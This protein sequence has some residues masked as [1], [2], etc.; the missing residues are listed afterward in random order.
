MLPNKGM[1]SDGRLRRPQLVPRAFGRRRQ[2]RKMGS[3]A[4]AYIFDD[5]AYRERVLP[6]LRRFVQT[7]GAD[8]WLD[9]LLRRLAGSVWEF[10]FPRI[11]GLGF[12]FDDVCDYL[13]TDFSFAASG[14]DQWSYRWEPRA[15][16]SATCPARELC[17]LHRSRQPPAA[18]DFNF[19]L[20]ACVVDQCLGLGQ[21]LGRTV[22]PLWYSDTLVA[23]GFSLEHP[24]FDCLRKL[25]YRGFVVGYQFA[26]SDGIHGW[27]TAGETEAFHAHLRGLD[28]PRFESSFAAMEG[29]R[30]DGG[31]E[32]PPQ[33][34]F[35]QLSLAFLRTVAGMAT[36]AGRGLLWGNDVSTYWKDEQT[37]EPLAAADPARKAGPCS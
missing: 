23:A 8:G 33:Y 31:Y 21:F 25:E 9:H 35:E 37:A 13:G 27:L 14:V 32:A 24:V 15:C 18:A 5:A 10:D 36:A 2:L 4:V 12:S 34:S 30:R 3:D 16:P 22:S 29:F 6:A 11:R 19:L 20:E 28:L 7:G 17:P 26:N 1:E